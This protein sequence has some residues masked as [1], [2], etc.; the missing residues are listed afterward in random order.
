VLGGRSVFTFSGCTSVSR[1][2]RRDSSERFLRIGFVLSNA[3]RIFAGLRNLYSYLYLLGLHDRPNVIC[4]CRHRELFRKQGNCST[5]CGPKAVVCILR[6][7]E[8]FCMRTFIVRPVVAELGVVSFQVWFEETAKNCP[9][10][11]PASQTRR[12][13]ISRLYLRHNTKHSI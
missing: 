9:A 13:K 10:P 3:S 6:C 7:A 5:H 1:S 4:W 11:S 2:R 12:E 8:H